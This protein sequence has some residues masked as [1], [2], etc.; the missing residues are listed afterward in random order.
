MAALARLALALLVPLLLEAHSPEPQSCHA[1]RAP[2]TLRVVFIRHAESFNNVLNLV[3]H[4]YYTQHRMADPPITPLGEEQAD[5]VGVFIAQSRSGLLQHISEILISPTIR[6]LQTAKPIVAR[7]PGVKAHVDVDIFEVGGVYLANRSTG[8]PVGEPG[9]T[10]VL[11]SEY[12][13]ELPDSVAE[14]G[15]YAHD[16]ET[17]ER[18]K[19]SK[20]EGAARAAKVAESL[21]STAAGLHERKTIAMVSHGDF[22]GYVLSHLLG[23]QGSHSKPA[24]KVYNTG[25]TCVDIKAD[26]S[27]LVLYVNSVSHLKQ[28]QYRAAHLGVV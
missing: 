28:S 6:T 22:I 18:H 8:Q 23:G 2:A 26:G 12:G 21:R 3:S 14:T 25:V 4:D 7:M 17:A 5:A 20:A 27:V 10:R 1:D 15:W 24:F 11:M 13:Y 9:L 16:D 19:E